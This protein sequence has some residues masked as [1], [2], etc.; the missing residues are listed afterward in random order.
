MVTA[1]QKAAAGILHIKTLPDEDEANNCIVKMK[2]QRYC[3]VKGT[4]G[5][6][7]AHIALPRHYCANPLTS[8]LAPASTF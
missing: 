1:C 3:E 6:V 8:W 2:K 5:G 7:L 4:L